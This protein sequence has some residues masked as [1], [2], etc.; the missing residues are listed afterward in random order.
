MKI[1]Q[2]K[3]RKIILKTVLLIILTVL[4]VLASSLNSFI[5]SGF[6]NFYSSKI[7]PYISMPAE[8]FN[9]FFHNSLTEGLVVCGFPLLAVCLISWIVILI[10]KMMTKGTSS[11]LYISYRNLMIILIVGSV[12]FQAMH[13]INYRRDDI[14]KELKLTDKEELTY[15]DYCAALKWAYLGMIEARSHL[16]EDF[17]GV[18]H[19]QTG[20]ENSSLYACSL[21]DSFSDE[22]G[23]PLSR[24]YVRAK[25]VSLS[26]YWSYTGIV[27]MYDMFLGEANINTDDMN[28][29]EFPA[30]ICHELCH[31]KGYASETDCNL[32]AT[33]A[34]CSSA[35][36]DFRYSGFQ[37]IFF[38][39]YY[40]TE[41]IAEE[42][43]QICPQYVYTSEMDAVYRDLNAYDMYWYSI[44]EEIA[45]IYD[46]SGVDIGE[47]SDNVNDA[48][49]KSNGEEEGIETYIVPDSIYVRFY[50]THIA[51]K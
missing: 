37:R 28:V 13:G 22:Y 30:T 20:F 25:P 31:A 38:D 23:I 6:A 26:H 50:L 29:T 15:E 49:L 47:T 33:L 7:F 39:L 2:K 43:G 34:C 11:Y 9:M 12:I 21:L 10:K 36:A 17:H 41:S 8:C 4:F 3:K 46:W 32:L 40:M 42:T 35:R 5:S 45:D 19:M 51:G 18:A 48:F 27:G 1:K 24:N 14:E 16:G 44:N